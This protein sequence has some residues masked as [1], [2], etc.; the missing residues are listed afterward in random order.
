DAGQ[1]R[2]HLRARSGTRI[3]ES[4]KLVDQVE[5]AI[6]TEV[7]AG[8]IAGILDNIGVPNSG[9][10]LSYSNSG[11]I[12]TGDADILVSLRRGHR[13]TQE[14]VRCLR[15]R[16]IREF[17][18][19]TFYFLPADIVSQTLNFGLPA[20][21]NIQIAGRDLNKNR[22]LAARLIDQVRQIPGAVDV[23]VQQPADLP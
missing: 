6:R 20:P 17:P 10:S 9:I 13:P 15:A 21:F 2:L 18:G 5:T 22:E 23:R 4:A 16:L 14:Y 1:F 7:P 8:E 3:E 19:T 12:G 11:L